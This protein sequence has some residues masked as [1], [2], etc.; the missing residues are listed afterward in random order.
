MIV[1]YYEP[2]S[3][4]DCISP[5]DNHP[6]H[7]AIPPLSLSQSLILLGRRHTSSDRQN[8]CINISALLT[9]QKY[10]RRSQLIRL[11]WPSHRRHKG[12]TESRHHRLTH[13][14]RNQRSP[15]R[16]RR[17]TIYSNSLLCQFL[18]QSLCKS[19]DGC[20]GRRIVEY[21]ALGLVGFNTT[22]LKE[23]R[24]GQ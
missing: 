12:S 11:C 20:F 23:G 13:R 15:Y 19:D 5:S 4:D 3:S 18:C 9:G 6:F 7:L 2:A 10:I 22:G 17:Y 24:K 1:F 14:S 8:F 16:T 21:N